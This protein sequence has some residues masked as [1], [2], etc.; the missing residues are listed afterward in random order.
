MKNSIIENIGNPAALETMYRQNT[1]QFTF[2][3][4]AVY[5]SI[6]DE[7]IAKVW[8]ERLHYVQPSV[9]WGNRNETDKQ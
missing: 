7:P 4:D 8:H 3:F 9:N 1:A 5:E 2:D 6:K